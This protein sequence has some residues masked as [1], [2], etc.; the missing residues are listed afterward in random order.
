MLHWRRLRLSLS[1]NLRIN[2]GI[3]AL[4]AFGAVGV[5]KRQQKRSANRVVDAQLSHTTVEN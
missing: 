3:L 1:P 2:L 4:G 5:L